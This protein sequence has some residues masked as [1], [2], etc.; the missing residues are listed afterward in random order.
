VLEA[1]CLN[2][3]INNSYEVKNDCL[4]YYSDIQKFHDWISLMLSTEV[5]FVFNSKH[6]RGTF[7]LV[8]EG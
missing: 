6:H 4:F 1:I 3:K 7:R 2:G 8:Q 5:M